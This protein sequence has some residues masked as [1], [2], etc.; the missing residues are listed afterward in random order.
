MTIFH[1]NP[2]WSQHQSAE[3]QKDVT[4]PYQKI[5]IVMILIYTCYA[6][7]ASFRVMVV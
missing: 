6:I 4:Q 5:R 2:F 7:T 3:T 1:S